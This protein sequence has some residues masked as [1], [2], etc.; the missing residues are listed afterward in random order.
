MIKETDWLVDFVCYIMIK[1]TDWL[2]DLVC[3]IMIKE[4]DWLVDLV[5]HGVNIVGHKVPNDAPEK[6]KQFFDN[7]RLMCEFDVYYR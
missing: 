1:E 4:T 2:V 5:N 6:C 7:V 3:Y